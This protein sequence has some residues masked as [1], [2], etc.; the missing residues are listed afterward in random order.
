MEKKNNIVKILIFAGIGLLAL[1]GIIFFMTKIVFKNN[2][3][4]TST[5]KAFFI[6]SS[7]ENKFAIYGRDGT[8]KT[9]FIYKEKGEF[10]NGYAVVTYS[11]NTKAI[12]NENGK[13][14]IKKGEYKYI[15]YSGGHFLLLTQEKNKLLDR[16]LKVVKEG[17]NLTMLSTYL[18]EMSIVADEAKIYFYSSNG[19]LMYEIEG[20]K[21][22]SS[23]D[24]VAREN[25]VDKIASVNYKKKNYVFDLKNE[26][27]VVSVDAGL[28]IGAALTDKVNRNSYV[29]FGDKDYI[30]SNNKIVAEKEKSSIRVENYNIIYKSQ[31]ILNNN[32]EVGIE[33]DKESKISFNSP[34]SYL[35][36]LKDSK[37][38]EVY[39]DGKLKTTIDGILTRSGIASGYVKDPYYVIRNKDKYL[40]IDKEGKTLMSYDFILDVNISEN[41][42]KVK[43]AGK[44]YYVDLNNKELTPKSDSESFVKL[45]NRFYFSKKDKLIDCKTNEELNYTLYRISRTGRYEHNDDDKYAILRNN[46]TSKYALFNTKENKVVEE[47]DKPINL[48]ENYY[49]V[50]HE[51]YSYVNYKAFYNNKTK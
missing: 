21:Y 39:S 41:M 14:V 13:D 4:K 9:D 30:V 25:T 10:I 46:K 7:K 28:T 22:I 2:S 43:D 3:V 45:G 1:L 51:Y 35:R 23:F 44:Y 47:Y 36:E 6:R 38:I 11:D 12:V 50:D 37:K 32:G 19:K 15:F 49:E 16:N 17:K 40:L 34:N 26:K 20:E 42:V 33:F 48:Q 24:I 8:K 31:V 18:K 29:V 27:F 5:S